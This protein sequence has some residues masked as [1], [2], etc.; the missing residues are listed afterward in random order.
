M[1]N[2]LTSNL[3]HGKDNSLNGDRKY[4]LGHWSFFGGKALAYLL[5]YWID[6]HHSGCG[7]WS[8]GEFTAAVL[9][10]PEIFLCCKMKHFD[11]KLCKLV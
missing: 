6:K 3:S 7:E 11:G 8:L 5:T 10:V 2:I 9:I 4:Y 1:S